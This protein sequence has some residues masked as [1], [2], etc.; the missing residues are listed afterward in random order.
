MIYFLKKGDF[1][2][3]CEIAGHTLSSTSWRDQQSCGAEQSLRQVVKTFIADVFCSKDVERYIF[4]KYNSPRYD[5]SLLKY[6]PFR[7]D[8][9]NEFFFDRDPRSVAAML[10]FYRIGKL[11]WW[12]NNLLI[13]IWWWSWYF[14]LSKGDNDDGDDW[15]FQLSRGVPDRLQWRAHLLG[16]Q[17]AFCRT[18]LSGAL[19]WQVGV[20]CNSFNVLTN[21]NSSITWPSCRSSHYPFHALL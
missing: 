13:S 6:N 21:I 16:N 19:L 18:L 2:D 8:G 10:N 14:Q 12:Q 20:A 1:W 9:N 15:C 5:I 17:W 4:A 3:S 7:Y 11:H